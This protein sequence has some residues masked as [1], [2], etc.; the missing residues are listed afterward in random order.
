ML[1]LNASV[2]DAATN[3]YDFSKSAAE[4]QYH[5]GDM[6]QTQHGAINLLNLV[7][8]DG[9]A[10]QPNPQG[11]TI[12]NNVPIP[13]Q[14]ENPSLLNHGGLTIQVVP[15]NRK[16]SVTL[17]FAENTGIADNQLWNFGV[18]GNRKVW[19]GQLST[20]D[21]QYLG[22]QQNGGRVRIAVN[23]TPDAPPSY[24]V[25]GTV[26]LTADPVNPQLANRGI[27]K[28]SF[29]RSS[30][31]LVDDVCMTDRSWRMPDWMEARPGFGGT[32]DLDERI[33][34]R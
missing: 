1:A 33:H 5:V 24:W 6:L 32:P 8:E 20:L 17:K 18:N 3:C 30:Q 27:S 7:S 9:T 25:R 22:S 21:G 34:A 10:T 15:Q 31:L 26:T 23:A 2:G 13:G 29:G 12:H 28:F 11:A 19:R 4:T 14:G 16:S